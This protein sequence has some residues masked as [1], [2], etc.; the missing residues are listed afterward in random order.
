MVSKEAIANRIAIADIK[1]QYALGLITREKARQEAEPIIKRINKRQ[2][3]IAK[4]WNKR[5]YPLDFVS[6]FR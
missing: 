6:L 3:E 2:A 5:H 4:K 1:R